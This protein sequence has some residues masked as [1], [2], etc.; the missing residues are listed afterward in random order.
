MSWND[1]A[2]DRDRWRALVK[3]SFS[4]NL[5]IFLLSHDLLASHSASRSESVR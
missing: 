3:A 1:L 2:Q 4:I 5:G